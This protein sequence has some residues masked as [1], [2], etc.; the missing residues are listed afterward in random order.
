[1]TLTQHTCPGEIGGSFYGDR[2][3]SIGG[4]MAARGGGRRDC[5]PHRVLFLNMK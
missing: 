3:S 2:V 1:M 5:W 4:R